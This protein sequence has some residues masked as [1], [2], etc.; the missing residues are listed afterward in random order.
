MEWI[1]L[2]WIVFATSDKSNTYKLRKIQGSIKSIDWLQTS[3]DMNMTISLVRKR[4]S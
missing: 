1:I 3:E 2:P 4:S